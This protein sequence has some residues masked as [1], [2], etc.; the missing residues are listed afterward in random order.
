VCC[1]ALQC[2]VSILMLIGLARA[3]GLTANC[4]SMLQCVA[5]CCSVLQCLQC[6]A[7]SYQHLDANWGKHGEGSHGSVLHRVAL[8]C[9]VLHCVALSYQ[10]FDANLGKRAK[11]HTVDLA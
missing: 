11:V 7:V 10:H 9:T 1:S 4:C 3:M 6:A 8:Y 2:R 5:V